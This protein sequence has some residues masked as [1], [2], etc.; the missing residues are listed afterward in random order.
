MEAGQGSPDERVPLF[1]SMDFSLAGCIDL[2]SL[3][4][5]SQRSFLSVDFIILC[6]HC[7]TPSRSQK[8]SN[9]RVMAKSQCHSQME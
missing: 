2:F 9:L 5:E 6:V 8:S 3:P 7:S 4:L 1:L